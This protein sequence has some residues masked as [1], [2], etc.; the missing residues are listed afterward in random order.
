MFL[1]DEEWEQ[2]KNEL[3]NIFKDIENPKVVK[4]AFVLDMIMRG[5]AYTFV[6]NKSKSFSL[7]ELKKRSLG[8]FNLQ[9]KNKTQNVAQRLMPQ[10]LATEVK[11]EI[12]TGDIPKK[13]RP[14]KP[15]KHP[16]LD[17][18]KIE[19]HKDLI[20]D[21]ITGKVLASI[22]IADRYILDEPKLDEQDKRV[23]EKIKKKRHVK[24]MEKGWKLIKKYGKKLKIIQ[25]HDT[26]IK[27]YVVNDLFG[28]GRIE[29]LLHDTEINYIYCD[30]ATKPIQ[31]EMR[32][33]KL[34]TNLKFSSKDELKDFILLLAF[35]MGKSIKKKHT[36]TEGKLRGFQ[37]R[38]DVGEHFDKPQFSFRRL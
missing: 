20:K 31:I 9:M 37:V 33:R 27:Y 26:M 34:E 2:Q 17:D 28:L 5:C 8:N 13:P 32:G 18:A 19:I 36:I 4:N 11:S 10:Q 30:D 14:D 29:P 23:L 35:K 24:N 1:Y 3:E 15:K 7:D 6:K 16:S 12:R 21:R 25:G 22:T 38:L